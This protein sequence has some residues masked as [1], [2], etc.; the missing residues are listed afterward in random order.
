MRLVE[1]SVPTGSLEAVKDV[2][3]DEEVHYIVTEESSGRDIAAIVSFP[4]PP[5]AVEPILD[6]LGDA[7]IDKEQYTVV[8]EANTVISRR[9]K[10]LQEHWAEDTDETA[11]IAQEELRARA[12]DLLP[13]PVT[14]AVM[15]A[16]SAIVATAGVMMDSAAVVVGSMVI[17]PLVGPALAASVGT[18]ID[19]RALSRTG[20]KWQVLGVIL[21][22]ASAT[23][24]ALLIR[25]VHLVPPGIDLLELAQIQERLTPDFLALA[26]ALGAGVAGAFSLATGVSAALVGVMIAVALIPPAAVIGIGLAWGMPTVVLGSSVLLALNVLA[27]NLA[28]LGVL[29]YLGYRPSAWF[30][31]GEAKAQI[32]RRVGV[33]VV[34]IVAISAFLGVV[35]FASY[36]AA[37]Q[38][39]DI[40]AAIEDVLS[41]QMYEAYT[42][43]EIEVQR[44]EQPLLAQPERVTVTLG[45]E[46]GSQITPIADAFAAAIAERIDT[47]LVVE[48][49]H[50]TLE[51]AG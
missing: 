46:A 28:A 29:W 1:I 41:E 6:A 33:L 30:R 10:E 37:V 17:A 8:T 18:V 40:N 49:R 50:Q 19:D 36:E 51:T 34:A 14:Y 43:L 48:V 32:V 24:F 39:D 5:E 45:R 31:L 26:I 4:L 35:T 15:T 9:F 11:K 2:L 22:V 20:V 44:D 27:I 25:T 47:E 7:G 23:A 42:L 38:E 21:A 16:V 13:T 3:E 12:D